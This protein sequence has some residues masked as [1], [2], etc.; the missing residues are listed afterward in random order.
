MPQPPKPG[1]G[2]CSRALDRS[3]D[4]PVEVFAL[5]G[6]ARIAADGGDLPRAAGLCK[7]ADRRM[8]A[9]SDFITDLDR[10]D[11]RAVRALT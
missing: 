7:E 5:D 10:T 6:L 1:L 2:S 9:A 4:A 3:G 11:A 8:E